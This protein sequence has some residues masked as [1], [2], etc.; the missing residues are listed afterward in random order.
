MDLA[1]LNWL[2]GAEGQTVLA[3]LADRALAER[4]A[5]RELARLRRS[6]T[7]DRAAAAVEVALARRRARLKFPQADRL[8]FTREALEQ[9]S[10]AP[11]AAHRAARLA[12]YE[13]LADLGCGAGGDALAFAASG[14]RVTAVDQDPLRLALCRANAEA[15]GLDGLIHTL[16]ADLRLSPPPPAAVLFCDPGRRA[17]GRRRHDPTHYEP[18]LAHILTWRTAQPALGLKLGPGLDRAGLPAEAEVELVSLDGELKELALW[19]GPLATLA[20]RA[21]L[22]RRQPDGTI[23]H[24]SLS[25]SAPLSPAASVCLAPAAFLYEPDPAVI[26][27]GLVSDLGQQIGAA[28]LD[29]QIAYLTAQTLLH[30]PFARVW[31]L[32]TW[33]PFALKPLRARLRELGAGEVTVKKRG[34]PLD[35]DALARQLHGTGPRSLVVVLTRVAGAPAALI[36]DPPVRDMV[37]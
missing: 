13:H 33:L 21:S 18:P 23:S 3:D 11:V 37:E 4:D 16:A 20:R 28:L 31:P 1:S 25:S 9:A 22:L 12:G 14:L 8:Y 19:C 27:A 29:P 10:A 34:S 30:T 17:E 32:I 26:R 6:L 36:C 7:P 15:L 2:L 24:F 35:C 5:L